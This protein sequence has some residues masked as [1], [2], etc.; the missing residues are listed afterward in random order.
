MKTQLSLKKVK[1][2]NGNI[3]KLGTNNLH[4]LTLRLNHFIPWQGDKINEAGIKACAE[5]ALAYNHLKQ[6]QNKS[7]GLALP[8]RDILPQWHTFLVQVCEN[9]AYSEMPRKNPA[10]AF[11]YLIPYFFLRGTGYRSSYHE[12]TLRYLQKWGY[13]KTT[14]VIPFRQLDRQYV[15][16]KSGLQ[17]RLPNWIS[18]YANTT[19]ACHRSSIYLDDAS[20]YSI[21]HTLFYLTDFGGQT[22]PLSDSE[23]KRLI[24]TV[25]SLLV[26]YWRC[27]NWDI[28]GELLIN[29]LNLNCKESNLIADA[30]RTFREAAQE[31]G[32]IPANHTV[33]A[34]L[35]SQSNDAS[36]PDLE[37]SYCYHTTLV[38]LLYCSIALL[39]SYSNE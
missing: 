20:V 24:T 8:L 10:Q 37:F 1:S 14:E 30:S 27:K 9:T 19:A 11:N 7:E 16:W 22:A 21:T 32:A 29:L 33:Q 34:Q 12:A 28:L 39:S 25:E 15:L 31:D 26:H 18:L 17:K 35:A 6:W 23:V 38:S 36:R 13:P 5:L 4:W 3:L 2:E